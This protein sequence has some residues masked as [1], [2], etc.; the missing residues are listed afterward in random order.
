MIKENLRR[1]GLRMT[2]QRMAILQFLEGNTDHPSAEDIFNE[3]KKQ[4]PMI[5]FATVYNTIEKLKSIDGILELNIDTSRRR[6]DP[7]I[8]PHHH[9][10]CTSCGKIVDIHRDFPLD[11]PAHISR[12]FQIEGNHVEFYGRCHNCKERKD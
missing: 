8:K 1:T 5:S 3:V 7:D 11:V 10:I 12:T 9:L 4:Y 2:P 6:Y